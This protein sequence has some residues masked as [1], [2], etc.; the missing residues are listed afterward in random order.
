MYDSIQPQSEAPQPQR[1]VLMR[2]DPNKRVPDE[3]WPAIRSMVESG[4]PYQELADRFGVKK[5]TIVKRASKER[6]LTPQRIAL[7]KNGNTK[8]DDPANLV[9][10]LWHQ[11]GV[12]TRDMVFQ[13]AAKSL[14][15]FFALS[16]I[17]QSFAEAS[18][19]L[20]MVN[21]AV[22]PSGSTDKQQNVSISILA[23]KGFSPSPVVDV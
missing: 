19:A 9:A 23:S 13:G 2:R 7:A 3:A 1:E 5:H 14:Q 12:E 11:R 20:K 6:W 16:P 21:D 15:R 4:V 22:N 10:A 17:P 8:T 18:T